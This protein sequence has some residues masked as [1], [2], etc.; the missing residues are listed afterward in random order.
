MFEAA[1]LGLYPAQFDTE[2]D[3]GRPTRDVECVR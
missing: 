2:V 3:G 1:I